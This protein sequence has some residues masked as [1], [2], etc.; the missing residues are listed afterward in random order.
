[1]NERYFIND[2][3]KE[4]PIGYIIAVPH[5]SFHPAGVIPCDGRQI[6]KDLYD[7]LYRIIGD[8]YNLDTDTSKYRFRVPDLTGYFHTEDEEAIATTS[9]DGEGDIICWLY[10]LGV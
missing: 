5:D 9:I 3:N 10:R 7:D 6:N 1:M 2:N 4:M 8:K